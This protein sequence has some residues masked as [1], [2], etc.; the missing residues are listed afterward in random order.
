MR[1]G[2]R[3]DDL[4]VDPHAHGRPDGELPFA[5][6]TPFDHV[7][8]GP[9]THAVVR[10]EAVVGNDEEPEVVARDHDGNRRE[11]E[12]GSQSLSDAPPPG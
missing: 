8:H 4:T 2:S 3:A 6:M 9:I 1:A 5:A 10:G 12:R 7:G 11:G